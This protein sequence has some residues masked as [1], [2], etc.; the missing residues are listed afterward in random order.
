MT[1][2]TLVGIRDLPYPSQRVPNIHA[3]V[4]VEVQTIR[5]LSNARNVPPRGGRCPTKKRGQCRSVRAQVHPVHNVPTLRSDPTVVPRAGRSQC[6]YE[7]SRP[8]R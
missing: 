5:A 6:R 4:I 3:S 8:E 7:N 1:N 2:H